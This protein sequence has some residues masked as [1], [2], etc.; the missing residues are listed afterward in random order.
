MWYN[1]N[2][3]MVT[4][5]SEKVKWRERRRR[6]RK[7]KKKEEEERSGGREREEGGEWRKGMEGE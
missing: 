5:Y 3:T 6:R 7:K 1:Q 4:E 2:T